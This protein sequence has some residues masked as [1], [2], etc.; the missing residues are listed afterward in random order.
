MTNSKA[1]PGSAQ[2]I[3]VLSKPV[4]ARLLGGLSANTNPAI[5]RLPEAVTAMLD[6][7]NWEQLESH[8]LNQAGA[9]SATD[10]NLEKLFAVVERA[11][12]EWESAIDAL[13]DLICLVDHT[14]A[15]LRA[16]RIVEEWQLGRVAMVRGLPLHQLLHPACSDQAC[17][18]DAVCR[19]VINQVIQGES[20]DQEAY[21]PVLQRH[22]HIHARP[23]LDRNQL[24]TD[25]AAVTVSDISER[26]RVE[27]ERER[28]IGD[29]DA[30][31]HTVAHDLKN[32]V[33]L[34]MGY[35]EYLDRELSAISLTEI[36]EHVQTIARVGSKL[37]DIIDELLLFAEVQEAQIET[38]PLEMG[39]IV[40]EALER[41]QPL[42]T[43]H[44]ASLTVPDAWP[45]VIGYRQWVEEV[46]VNYVSNAVKYGGPAPRVELGADPPANGRVRFW[47]KDEGPGI[48]PEQQAHVFSRFGQGAG[49]SAKGHGLGLSIV[50]RIIEKLGGQ[51]GLDSPATSGAGSLFYFTLPVTGHGQD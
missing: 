26:R 46:W 14:G 32:P 47:V 44:A 23:V 42:T 37:N 12:R 45:T 29:L 43:Q 20:I 24:S 21:D 15:I 9:N 48:P 33:G 51:V 38:R 7:K 34:V 19:Q 40:A 27:L 5:S 6:A 13:P 10:A 16:N 41:L 8:W 50:Q 36:R 35:A 22:V 11:K 49:R 39:S 1:S 2:S 28:L 18:L 25:T 17:Y 4:L 30:Y 3:A 31:A